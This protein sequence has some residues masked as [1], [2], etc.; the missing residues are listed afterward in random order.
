LA[1]HFIGA[2]NQEPAA[3]RLVDRYSSG[4][5]TRLQIAVRGAVQGVGFRPFVYRLAREL[6]LTGWVNNTPQ[7]VFIEVEGVQRTV[8][9]FKFRLPS[10]APPLARII[11]IE[12]RELPPVGFTAFEIRPSEEGGSKATIILPDIAVC[13]ECRRELFDPTDRRYRYPFINCTH[14]GPR[15]SI[16]LRLPYDRPNT[17]MASFRMCADCLTEYNAPADRRFHAQPIACPKCGPT[18]ELWNPAGELISRGEDAFGTVI[19][20]LKEGKVVALKGLGGFHLLVNAGDSSAVHTLRRRKKRGAKPF[21]VMFPSLESVKRSC[22]ASLEESQLLCS[23]EAPIALLMRRSCLE[24]S[25][26][27]A[28]GN[29]YLGAILPYTPL[30]HLLMHDFG[31]PLVATSGNLSDEPICTD[32]QDALVRLHDIADL[33][34]VHNR[35]IARQVDDSVVR[36]INGRE[37]VLRRARG[38]APLPMPLIPSNKKI[39]AF[40]G[41]LKNCITLNTECGVVVSQHIGDLDARPGA[42]AFDR[43]RSDLAT[44]CGIQP[45]IVI[46]DLHPDYYSTLRAEESGLPVI[47]VQHHLAHVL[48]CAAENET[49]LPYYG[50]AWD[51]TGYGGDG[52]IWGGE[53]FYVNEK[54]VIRTGSLLAAPLVGGDAAVR[55]PRRSALGVLW[56][57]F[58]EEIVLM[59]DLPPIAAMNSREL[60]GFT[61]MLRRGVN[62]K[63]ATSMG[64]LF[65]AVSS[66]ANLCHINRFEGEAAMALEFAAHDLRSENAY[67]FKWINTPRDQSTESYST[68][69]VYRGEGGKNVISPPPIWRLD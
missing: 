67:T 53:F 37:Q 63:Q 4:Q 44:L 34:L 56:A 19:A 5:T 58:G 68:L 46:C 69:I 3:E 12:A 9:E 36:I 16:I 55:E 6:N 32:E 35:P 13:S 62:V 33:F 26:E 52:T 23:P 7:G 49:A 14:C 59:T 24:V 29:P 50:V 30:H 1:P 8:A 45:E 21:A 25:A 39:I 42:E 54:T 28:P 17:T 2:K 20:A 15:Y 10:E 48:S 65:D 57:A 18:L 22:E 27:V 41:H 60:E 64:R 66:L 61:G 31:A 43:V 38:L 11:S 40:G 51:G 47:R